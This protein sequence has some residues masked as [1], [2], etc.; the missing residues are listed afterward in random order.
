MNII[1]KLRS[2]HSDITTSKNGVK[3][4]DAWQLAERL[5]LR[6]PVDLEE[7]DRVFKEQDAAG[8]LA[9]I[10]KLE[11]PAEKP[12]QALPEFHHDDLAAAMR[13]FKK[14]LKLARLSDESRLGNRYTTGGRHSKIDAIEPPTEFD[15]LIW[16]V[17]ARD[18]KLKDTGGG[19]YQLGTES[20]KP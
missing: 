1:Q 10:D 2:L 9:M 4:V 16:K 7:A 15:P 6:M 13:A 18:G 20:G 19:F 14:R 3:I 5:A 11:K 12:Q 8:L 17:L